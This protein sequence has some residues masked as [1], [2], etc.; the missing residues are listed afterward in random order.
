MSHVSEWVELVLCHR[1]AWDF[2]VA[3]VSTPRW[4]R[5][6]RPELRATKVSITSGVQRLASGKGNREHLPTA[7][8]AQSLGM[9]ARAEYLSGEDE[10]RALQVRPDGLIDARLTLVRGRLLVVNPTGWIN[11]KSR[12]A[13]KSGLHSFQL[14]GSHHYQTALT[15]GRFT[16]GALVRLVREPNNPHDPN[17]IAVY[18]EGAA[19][20]SDMCQ[21][22]GPNESQNWWIQA[23]RL[24][25]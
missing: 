3:H 9:V 8:L 21:L 11:P 18:A 22:R 2:S 1:A 7:S 19:S 4:T 25:R 23:S 14:H 12:I 20:K 15:S 10:A 17:A 5:T 6:R 16:P 24:S 13:Y